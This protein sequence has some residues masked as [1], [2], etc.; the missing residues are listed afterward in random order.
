MHLA[1]ESRELSLTPLTANRLLSVTDHLNL[2]GSDSLYPFHSPLSPA[3]HPHTA[4]PSPGCVTV[5]HGASCAHERAHCT[6]DLGVEMERLPQ[7]ACW[8]CLVEEEKKKLKHLPPST[9]HLRVVRSLVYPSMFHSLHK[10][11]HCGISNQQRSTAVCSP[12]RGWSK[13]RVEGGAETVLAP[14]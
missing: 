5:T 12:F 13:K 1:Y 7:A 8:I 3:R 10:S 6:L 11:P 2:N 9:P 14:R 4:H